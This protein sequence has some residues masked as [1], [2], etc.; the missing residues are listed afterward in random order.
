MKQ[1]AGL[2]L[3][4]V[5][6]LAGVMVP[7]ALE[8]AVHCN[9]N[10]PEA[11]IL[12]VVLQLPNVLMIPVAVNVLA[13]LMELVARLEAVRLAKDVRHVL[14]ILLG[15]PQPLNVLTIL[16]VLAVF[17]LG[18]MLVVLEMVVLLIECI[19]QEQLIS[20]QIAHL[21]PSVPQRPLALLHVRFPYLPHL[22]LP[23]MV[24]VPF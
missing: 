1:N 17:H 7:A 11:V 4:V 5:P 9:V 3:P 19:K 16:L 24:K 20:Q 8:V 23:F 10:K 12:P 6:V 21:L 22:S 2:I 15:V 13:G 14:V 18:R